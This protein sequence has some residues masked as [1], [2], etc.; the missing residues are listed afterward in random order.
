MTTEYADARQYVA[1]DLD[2]DYQVHTNPST[3][4][5]YQLRLDY[6]QLLAAAYQYAKTRQAV[7]DPGFLGLRILLN[8]PVR[9]CPA[10]AL[11]TKSELDDGAP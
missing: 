5:S 1:A 11:S 3:G 10:C 6:R 4:E 8:D 7:R 2:P 9:D